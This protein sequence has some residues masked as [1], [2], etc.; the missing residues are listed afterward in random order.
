MQAKKTGYN[1]IIAKSDT[2]YLQDEATR[3]ACAFHE[4]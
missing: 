4:F 3:A 1:L 2:V